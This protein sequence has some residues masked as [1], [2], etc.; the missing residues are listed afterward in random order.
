MAPAGR[1]YIHESEPSYEEL[2]TKE[3]I[4]LFRRAQQRLAADK[5]SNKSNISFKPL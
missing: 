4:D 2:G 1:Q 3:D 5:V